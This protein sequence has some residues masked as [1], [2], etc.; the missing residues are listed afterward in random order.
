MKKITSLKGISF[1][2]LVG[3]LMTGVKLSAQEDKNKLLTDRFLA[4]AALFV[5]DRQVEVGVDAN[6]EITEL[7]GID[8]DRT[9]GIGGA[10]TTFNMDFTWRF[11]KSKLWSVTGQYFRVSARGEAVLEED[12]V[13]E[14]VTFEAGSGVSAGFGFSLF[15]AFFGRV[16]STGD[17]HELGA[18]LGIH[19]VRPDA[20]VEGNA[21]INGQDVGFRR[22]D[23]DILLPLPNIGAWYTWAPSKRWSFMAN[24]DWLFINIGDISGG[25]WNISPRVNFQII[26][27]LGLSV[28]YHYLNYYAEFNNKNWKGNF[29]M[30]F[31]GPSFGVTANF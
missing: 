12:V 4:R 20:F 26:D 3:F 17:K 30:A 19:A 1:L 2:L 9:F 21:T 22:Q 25:L 15:R 11:S 10:Q 31:T 14:D 16:I 8:F 29:D 7:G 5:P 13:W 28:A 23:V 18:G 27:N 24:V 6:L